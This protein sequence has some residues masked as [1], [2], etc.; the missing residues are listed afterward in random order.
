MTDMLRDFHRNQ[1]KINNQQNSLEYILS[2][3]VA[4]TK[5]HADQ[6]NRYDLDYPSVG[7]ASTSSTNNCNQAV[8]VPSIKPPNAISADSSSSSTT[9]ETLTDAGPPFNSLIGAACLE[10]QQ[11]YP[12]AKKDREK[13]VRTSAQTL[14]EIMTGE[15]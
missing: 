4:S 14:A 15:N 3:Y 7:S 12:F 10:T 13:E 1:I 5:T 11:R 9:A 8:T 2:S 6:L